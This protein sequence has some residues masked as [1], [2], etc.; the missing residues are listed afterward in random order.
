LNLEDRR[1]EMSTP[2][3]GVWTYREMAWTQAD[4]S[5]YKVE[6]KDG[7]IGKIDEASNEV[8]SAYIVVDTGPWI[9]GKKVMIP[10][11]VIRDVDPDSETVLVDRTKDEIKNSPEYDPDTFKDPMYRDKLG[12]YYGDR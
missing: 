7:S 3:T 1:Y 5:G 10:A 12:S 2:T 8:G 9:L 4:L 11:G 6:A